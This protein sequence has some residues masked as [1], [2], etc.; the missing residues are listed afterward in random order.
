MN[1]RKAAIENL[2]SRQEKLLI[3]EHERLIENEG[4]EKTIGRD[5]IIEQ[6]N[7]NIAHLTDEIERLKNVD[8]KEV[9]GTEKPGS[10]K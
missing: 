1:Y 2:I 7:K 9:T 4:K 6:C 10:T 3:M 8:S 5:N